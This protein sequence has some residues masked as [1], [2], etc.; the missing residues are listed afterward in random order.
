MVT[1]HDSCT[2]KE[3]A[4]CLDEADIYSDMPEWTFIEVETP[5]EL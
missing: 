2:Y 1:R 5:G 4:Q 3:V